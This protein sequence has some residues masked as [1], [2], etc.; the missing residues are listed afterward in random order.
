MN[1]RMAIADTFSLARFGA[2]ALK[3][4]VQMRRDRLTF[5]MIIGIPILQLVLFG[6][7]INSDPKSLPTAVVD[8]DKSEFSRSIVRGLENTRYFEMTSSP[9]SEMEADR[10]LSRGDVQFSIV[11][12]SDFSRR[13]LRGEKPQLLLAADG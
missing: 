10:L 1:A 8:Y 4:F 13:L 5:G 12:P 7:A 6:Y 3:E 11:F 9:Q 2:I